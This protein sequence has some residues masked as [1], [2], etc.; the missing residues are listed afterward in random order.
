MNAAI[1]QTLRSKLIGD[2]TEDLYSS[3]KVGS[4]DSGLSK[5][6]PICIYVCDME[7]KKQEFKFYL[8]PSSGENAAQNRE[9]FLTQISM[10]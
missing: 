3:A 10:E 8:V 6:N 7:R 2:M 9:L 5:V 4:D 1:Y